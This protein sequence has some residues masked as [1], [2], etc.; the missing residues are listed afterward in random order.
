[1]E[2]VIIVSVLSTLG[3]VAVLTSV[4]VAFIKLK[5]KVDVSLFD[6]TIERLHNKID[7]EVYQAIGENQRITNDLISDTNSRIEE[8]TKMI[9]SRCDKL[10][11]KIKT[12]QTAVNNSL[13]NN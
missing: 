6:S 13:M 12:V 10:D 4:V 7:Y 2:T 9:D 1:M 11:S 3:V 8:I 5:N